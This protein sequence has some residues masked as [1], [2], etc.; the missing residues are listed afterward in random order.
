MGVRFAVA[1]LN[2]Y[3]ADA[4]SNEESNPAIADFSHEA[5]RQRTCSSGDPMILPQRDVPNRFAN[6]RHRA[7]IVVLTQ[8][9]L[10][11]RL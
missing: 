2:R 10:V 4:M 9:R 6:L 7:K 11:A 3:G 8:L 5:A 1:R